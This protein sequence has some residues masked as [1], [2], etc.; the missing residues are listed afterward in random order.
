MLDIKADYDTVQYENGEF[1]ANIFRLMLVP[2]NLFGTT[3]A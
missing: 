1:H 2:T 3:R